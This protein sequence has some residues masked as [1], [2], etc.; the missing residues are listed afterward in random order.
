M[1]RKAHMH[2]T[3]DSFEKVPTVKTTIFIY[4][5]LTAVLKRRKKVGEGGAYPEHVHTTCIVSLINVVVFS[6]FFF[7]LFVRLDHSSNI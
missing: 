3:N 2:S 7:Q 6:A 4:H 1:L 5:H